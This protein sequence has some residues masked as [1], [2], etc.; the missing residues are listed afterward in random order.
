MQIEI[1]FLLIDKEINVE[2]IKCT[3]NVIELYRETI[4]IDYP[5]KIDEGLFG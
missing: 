5:E 2:F 1:S 3:L 4:Y